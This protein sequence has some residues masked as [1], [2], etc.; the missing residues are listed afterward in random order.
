MKRILKNTSWLLVG[1]LVRMLFQFAVSVL[2]ARYLGPEQQGKI[3]YVA[4]YVAFFST[5]VGLG[6]NGVIIHE[7]VSYREQG[8]I[9]GTALVL[10]FCTGLISLALMIL[11]M[12][13]LEPGNAEIR[14][15][16]VLQAVQLPFAAMDTVKYVYQWKL[17][18]YRSVLVTS[19]GYAVSCIFKLYLIA[20]HKS[21]IWFGFAGSLDVISIG[22]FYLL[23][24]RRNKEEPFSWSSEA[25]KRML[26]GCAPFI[27]ANLMAF[28]YSRIDT[29][30]I[31]YM[32]GSMELVGLYGTAVTICGLISFVPTA[33]LDSARPV[34]ME[35][36]RT[37]DAVYQKRMRQL[38]LGVVAVAAAYSLFVTVFGRYLI[39]LLYGKAYLGALESLR[40]AV[41]YSAFS[42]LGGVKSVWLICE[43]KSRFVFLFAVL[44]A[45]TNVLL[46]AIMIPWLSIKGAA[47]AT[48]VTQCLTNLVYPCLWK[49][50]RGFAICV[51]DAVLLRGKY[52]L[53]PEQWKRRR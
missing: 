43:N 39:M 49:E 41:W 44:G 40:V 22:A 2:I 20:A 29:I 45:A 47:C 46:N 30:M 1:N 13:L 25:A 34:V 27:L 23:S 15:I 9:L 14:T 7:L 53:I 26:R 12:C 5:I 48:L 35:A 28:V 52:E 21:V 51:R 17:E 50:T 36:K 24:Y 32:T 37:N 4:A 42:F 18:S 38:C 19:A 10:R 31:R 6:I 11:L 16:S 33:L 8:R 3:N